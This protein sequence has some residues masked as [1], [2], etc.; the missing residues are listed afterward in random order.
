MIRTSRFFKQFCAFFGNNSRLFLF[1]ALVVCGVGVGCFAFAALPAA[2]TPL[3]ELMTP[4]LPEQLRFLP[5]LAAFFQNSLV[6]LTVIGLLMLFGMSL[7]GLPAV[8]VLPFGYGVALGLGEMT[9]VKTAGVVGLLLS[10]PGALVAV[11][12]VLIAC[13][14]ALKLT[15]RLI[16]QV[17]PSPPKGGLWRD[18]RLFFL[19]FILCFLLG[20][21]AS[22]IQTTMAVFV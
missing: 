1:L 19:R 5:V 9:V 18:F 16:A 8:A 13:A 21:L 20:L 7:Y 3:L 17:M 14:Q 22:A 15:L 11:W 10:L 4:R 6:T 2:A 12:A